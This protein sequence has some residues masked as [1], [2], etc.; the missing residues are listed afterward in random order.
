M[1]CPDTRPSCTGRTRYLRSRRCSAGRLLC[2][3]FGID[4]SAARAHV[5]NAFAHTREAKHACPCAN[6]HTHPARTGKCSGKRVAALHETAHTEGRQPAQMGRR[7]PVEPATDTAMAEPRRG[8]T[9]RP[10]CAGRVMHPPCTLAAACTRWPRRT[11][12]CLASLGF[13]RFAPAG[14]RRGRHTRGCLRPPRRHASRR[15]EQGSE[16]VR[17]E[18]GSNELT[19]VGCAEKRPGLT[20]ATERGVNMCVTNAGERAMEEGARKR[21]GGEYSEH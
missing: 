2:S 1:A 15:D 10:R 7:G 19:Q 4:R 18:E 12:P 14:T 17:G 8:C 3:R 11:D 21:G 9:G 5:V 20:C 6:K 13:A 16:C